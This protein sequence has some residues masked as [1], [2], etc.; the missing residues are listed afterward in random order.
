MAAIDQGEMESDRVSEKVKEF[1]KD[2]CGCALGK[3][4]KSISF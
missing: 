2:G 4:H 1:L 3:F